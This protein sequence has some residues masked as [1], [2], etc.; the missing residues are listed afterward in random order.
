[1]KTAPPSRSSASL[2]WLARSRDASG[3]P[4]A[5]AAA[6]AGRARRRAAAPSPSR[7]S[8]RLRGAVASV[9]VS[10]AVTAGAALLLGGCA[11]EAKLPARAVELNRAGA[12]AL[13]AGDYETAEAR[14]GVALEYSPRFTEAWV[15]LG[16]VEMKRGAIDRAR[17][18]LG[19]ARSLNPDLPAPHHAL[20]LVEEVRGRARDAEKHYRE[21]I[22]VDPGFAPSRANL[23]RLLFAR[24]AWDDAREQFLRLTEVAPESLDGWLGLVESLVRAAREGDAD[25]ALDRARGRFGDRPELVLL[26]ARQMLRREAYAAAEEALAPLTAGDDPDRRAAAWAWIAVARLGAGERDRA[27][28]AATQAL[29]IRRDAVALYVVDALAARDRLAPPSPARRS[30]D[31]EPG[32]TRAIPRAVRGDAAVSAVRGDGAVS[33]ERG[34]PSRRAPR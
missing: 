28:N 15:N 10:A 1:M 14:L 8:S 21:A 23:G 6:G 31:A 27:A 26:V 4:D 33:E 30:G 19:R 17:R 2:S 32:E 22:H 16:L 12:A 25:A 3:A 5:S 29:A 7:A 34:T 18:D 20:G 24:G 9:L 13:A 11:G